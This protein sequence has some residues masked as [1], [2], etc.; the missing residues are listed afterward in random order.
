MKKA[1]K[2]L[3]TI[4]AMA[5][6]QKRLWSQTKEY[7]VGFH[8]KETNENSILL[9]PEKFKGIE[10]NEFIEIKFVSKEINLIFQFDKSK[11]FRKIKENVSLVSS[12]I[13]AIKEYYNY[14]VNK[15]FVF[16][17]VPK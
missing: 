12:F 4:L 5:A 7:S 6:G 17:T 13:E 11:N 16:A 9:D 2:R 14:V 15:S 3:E 10:K 1:H 8:Y